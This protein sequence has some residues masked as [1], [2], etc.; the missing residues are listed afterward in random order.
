V[1]IN[2]PG[3]D[4]LLSGRVWFPWQPG[5]E[6]ATD[7]P[8]VVS[9]T[10]FTMHSLRSLPGIART[11]RRLGLGWYAVPGA[12]GV[13]LWADP[14]RRRVGSLSVW[15]DLRAMRRWVGLPLHVATMRR[16]RTRGSVRST[17]WHQERLDREAVVAEATRILGG[18]QRGR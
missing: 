1:P 8:V 7:G 4:A 15:T 6:A 3:A 16:Y 18:G 5:P 2:P 13:H 12:V 10:D 14:V 11:G 9:L 17:T